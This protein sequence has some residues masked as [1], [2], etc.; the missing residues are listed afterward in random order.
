MIGTGLSR[1]NRETHRVG[2]ARVREG[3]K[4]VDTKVRQR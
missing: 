4:K 1:T 3:E 2:V